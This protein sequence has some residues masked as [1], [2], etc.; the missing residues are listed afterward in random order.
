MDKSTNNWLLEAI[1]SYEPDFNPSYA[2]QVIDNG[3]KMENLNLQANATIGNEII[4]LKSK[5]KITNAK[6]LKLLLSGDLPS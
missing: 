4:V 6:I 1:R 3:I 2:I 5:R